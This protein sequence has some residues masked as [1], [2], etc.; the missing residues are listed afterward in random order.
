MMPKLFRLVGAAMLL[1]LLWAPQEAQ[2]QAWIRDPGSF[3]LNLG[4]RYIGAN[5]FYNLDGDVQDIRS[6]RQH[7]LALYA[8]AGVID[9]WLMVNLEGELFR[10]NVL[11]D[12]AAV[13]GLGDMRL[14]LWTGILEAPF[15]LSAGVQV[16]L[17]FGDASPDADSDDPADQ[18]AAD[19]L[20]TGDGEVD[21]TLRLVAGH[22]FRWRRVNQ[23]VQG[24]IGYSIRTT[25][26]DAPASIGEPQ[27]IRDQLVYRIETGIQIDRPFWDRIWWIV[28]V[29]GL[30]IVQDRNASSLNSSLSGLGDGVEYAAFGIEALV[31]IGGGFGVGLGMDGAF[32]ARHVPAAPA[33]KFSLTYERRAQ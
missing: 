9:R 28:R 18:I 1:A 6:F 25:P 33:F 24:D 29:Q 26:R 31:N 11:V 21:V 10:R 30:A 22:G 15:R 16:G 19:L 3:Y 7:S 5:K 32:Y 14:G 8:E 27:D 13:S 2:A 20:G 17:P 23:F 4:Y 12:Q